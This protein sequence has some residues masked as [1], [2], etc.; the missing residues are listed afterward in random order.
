VQKRV[1]IVGDKISAYWV[2]VWATPKEGD[3]FQFLGVDGRIILKWF[4]KKLV[5]SVDWIRL[6]QERDIWW[7]L[8]NT[9]MYLGTP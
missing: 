4:L 9:E 2:L 1:A 8:V 3:L 5:E 7:G 6:A